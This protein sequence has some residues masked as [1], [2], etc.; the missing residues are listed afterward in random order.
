[1]PSSIGSARQKYTP[2]GSAVVTRAALARGASIVCRTVEHPES[3]QINTRAPFAD[4]PFC[5]RSVGCAEV[6][7]RP[8]SGAIGRGA[9]SGSHLDPTAKYPG[10]QRT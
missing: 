5:H 6:T 4:A 8:E 10:S 1:V 2:D 7:H 3:R 9:G